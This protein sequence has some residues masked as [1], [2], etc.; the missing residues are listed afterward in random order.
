MYILSNFTNADRD[1]CLPIIDLLL[2]YANLARMEGI[3]ALEDYVHKHDNDFLTFVTMMVVDG[4]DPALVRAI[5]EN[6]INS[7]GYTGGALL[8]RI[9]ISEGVLAV[10]AGENPHIIEL[11]L[12]SMFGEDYLK[13]Q[14]RFPPP[15]FGDILYEEDLNRRIAALINKN[16][17]SESA[18]FNKTILEMSNRDIQFAIRETDPRVM[19][20]AII[21]CTQEAARRLLNNLSKR[22][23]VMVL[24]DAEF[25]CSLISANEILEDQQYIMNI[26]NRLVDSGEIIKVTNICWPIMEE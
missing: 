23:A 18:N 26:I 15:P 17:L 1:A 22:A 20:T 8:E 11:K 14:G 25:M 3:L 16:N 12:F 7:S 19:A 2:D 21:G 13:K 4:T 5:I 6:L 9:L 24:E 10:Q